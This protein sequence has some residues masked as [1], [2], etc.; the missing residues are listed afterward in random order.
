[1]EWSVTLECDMWYC[2]IREWIQPDFLT[3][4]RDGPDTRLSS[5]ETLKCST[6]LDDRYESAM[7]EART[8]L[9]DQRRSTIHKGSMDGV[10]DPY[11][12][13]KIAKQNKDHNSV[14]VLSSA[15]EAAMTPEYQLVQGLISGLA[16][17]ER[18]ASR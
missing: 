11:L 4:L 13:S 15:S 12:W 18:T 17:E 10:I 1:M 9:G 3:A 7:D 8:R 2:T 14:P 6:R 5:L 16:T